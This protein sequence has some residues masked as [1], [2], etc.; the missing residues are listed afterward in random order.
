LVEFALIS[1]FL[2]TM[3]KSVITLAPPFQVGSVLETLPW[4]VSGGR[5][6]NFTYAF[7]LQSAT[8]FWIK[9][10]NAKIEISRGFVRRI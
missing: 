5:E 7:D 4:I 9:R 1:L 2:A 10:M 8:A 6:K 3:A